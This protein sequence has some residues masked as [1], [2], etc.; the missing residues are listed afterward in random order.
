MSELTNINEITAAVLS[1]FPDAMLYDDNGRISIDP[2]LES[3]S[4]GDFAGS[5]NRPGNTL[6]PIPDESVRVVVLNDGETFSDA[7]GCKVFDVAE[8]VANDLHFSDAL[9]LNE[10]RPEGVDFVAEFG[11]EGLV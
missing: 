1:I 2:G 3:I 9:W 8:E 4:K 7:V 11:P 6:P 5:F 10:P